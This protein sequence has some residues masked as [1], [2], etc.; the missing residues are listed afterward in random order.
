MTRKDP[1][2]IEFKKVTCSSE[3]N[4]R[5]EAEQLAAAGVAFILVGVN[6]AK[7]AQFFKTLSERWGLHTRSEP[8]RRRAY[9][10]KA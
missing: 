2:A 7:D 1:G 4:W 6:F 8:N 10:W 5:S 9:F 3:K